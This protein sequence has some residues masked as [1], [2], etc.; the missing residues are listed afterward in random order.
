MEALLVLGALREAVAET[1]TGKQEEVGY[2][3][4]GMQLAAHCRKVVGGRAVMTER[5][6]CPRVP[7]LRPET[8]AARAAL[9]LKE[10]PQS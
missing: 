1:P 4:T 6:R 3:V 7:S 8:Q 5:H 2:R 9:P 10:A